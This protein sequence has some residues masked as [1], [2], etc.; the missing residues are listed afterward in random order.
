[1]CK[2]KH[3]YFDVN[4]LINDLNNNDLLERLQIQNKLLRLKNMFVNQNGK[5]Y[6]Y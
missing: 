6:F 5:W 2:I 1:M 4:H 3:A